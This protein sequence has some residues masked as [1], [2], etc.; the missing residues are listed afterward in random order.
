MLPLSPSKQNKI[1]T[2]VE[3]KTHLHDVDHGIGASKYCAGNTV[4]AGIL[5]GEI[6]G[7]S[8][9]CLKVTQGMDGGAPK[10]LS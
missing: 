6:S 5:E 4:G 10:A 3:D 9:V 7:S 1:N 8:S 2:G